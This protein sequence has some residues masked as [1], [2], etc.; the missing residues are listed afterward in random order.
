MNILFLSLNVFIYLFL[1]ADF[2][3]FQK[4]LQTLASV[5]GLLTEG[6]SPLQS[7]GSEALG[8]R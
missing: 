7:M 3:S 2:L 6:A 1:C 8:L 4:R 5:Y